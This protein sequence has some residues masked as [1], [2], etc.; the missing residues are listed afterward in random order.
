MSANGQPACRTALFFRTLSLLSYCLVAFF[1][2]GVL[3]PQFAHAQRLPQNVI[4]EHYT[5]VLTPHLKSATFSGQEKIEVLIKQPTATITLNAAQIKFKS[6][7]E[8]AD[9]KTLTPTITQDKQKEQTTFHF[10]RTLNPGHYTLTI[11]YS[12]ILNNQ[13]RGFYLSTQAGKRYAVT[14]FEPTDARRAFPSFDE[15]AFKATFDVTLIAP[16]GDMAISNTNVISDTPGPG[17]GEHTVHFATTPRMSTYLV[18]FLVGDFEC[19]K[20][21]SDG[22]PIRVCSPPD[23]IQYTHFALKTA[24]YVLH[25]YDTYF[26]IKYPMPKLDLIAIPDFEAGAMENFGAITFRDTAL[27]IDPSTATLGEKKVV[28]EDV[29]HEMAHQW[30]G[31]MV[32]MQ[33]W[34]NIWLNEGFATWMEHKPIA[35]MHPNWF[36]KD[37]VA[38][39]VNGTLN[40]DAQRVTRAI[41]AP[42]NTPA[43]IN[44]M[45]DGIS[46]G[47]ASAVLNMVEHYEGKETFRKGVHK[48]LEAHMY[49]NADA[50][51]FWNAQTAVSGLPVNKIMRSFITEP[52]VPGLTFGAPR[53]GMVDVTQRRFYLNSDVK[54]TAQQMWTVPVCFQTV[55]GGEKCDVLSRATQ[56]LSVPASSVLFPDANSMGY[57]RYTFSNRKT[58]N[59]TMHELETELTPADRISLFG[60][61]WAYVHADQNSVG[62]Y[63]NLVEKVKNDSNADVLGTALAPIGEIEDRIASNP[64]EVAAIHTWLIRT[65]EPEYK[66]LGPP[67]ASDSENTKELRAE[68]FGILGNAQDPAVTAAARKMADEYLANP[69]SVDPTIAHVALAIA[70]ANGD[71]AFFDELRHIY[72]TSTNPDLKVTALRLLVTFKN[73]KIEERALEYDVSGK[74]RNQDS[75]IEL[76]IALSDPNTHDVAWQFM[77]HHWPQVKAQNTAFLMGGFLV[78]STGSFCSARKEAE[79]QQF[80]TTH[81]VPASQ[82]ALVRAT[83]AINDCMTIRSQQEGNLRHWIEQEKKGA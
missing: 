21:Q 32:T 47:K 2:V 67:H 64:R 81:K 41:R 56:D 44:Q 55:N 23:Q 26:N 29:A 49:A 40:L 27:L 8:Q 60:D 63:L 58:A 11:S 35:A 33:W 3:L 1:L 68:L 57:Y 79:V 48:Y 13:L 39:G 12:G 37:D 5:L 17:P 22:V 10:N 45:F 38:E 83:Q 70:A 74:V 72:E 16:K 82:R 53:N 76:A 46:Y 30:F 59:R 65:F 6:V 36:V 15:P 80:F 19:V 62:T 77:Q 34:N 52:G 71:A 54:N 14:Q 75:I 25:Y 51:D 18:A 50:Q 42:A 7:T 78:G 73:R 69:A 66:R 61:L 4:P 24:E 28:A 20:G 43:Q 9:G 31:D